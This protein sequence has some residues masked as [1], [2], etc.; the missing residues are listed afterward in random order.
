MNID[1]AF[2]YIESFTNLERG[3]HTSMRPYRLD[4]MAILLHVFG[5]PHKTAKTIH[6]AG[7]KGKGSTAVF[8]ASSLRAAGYKT[9]LYTSPHVSSYKERITLAGEEID[10]VTITECAEDIRRTIEDGARL[11]LPGR[12][13]PTTFELLT[14]LAFLFQAK[15]R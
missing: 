10:D 5:Y 14:L 8:I 1:E 9:G 11:E 12:S 6:I 15:S 7:S 2:S 13:D 3:G 4:R